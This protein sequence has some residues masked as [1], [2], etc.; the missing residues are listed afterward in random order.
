MPRRVC[1]RVTIPVIL[2]ERSQVIGADIR[3]TQDVPASQHLALGE[4]VARTL[5][6]SSG[7]LLA[8]HGAVACGRTV[9][10][11]VFAAQ[12]GERIA[13]MYL[14]ARAAATP[15]PFPQAFADSERER[16]LYRYGSAAD[17]AIAEGA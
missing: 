16:W 8:N 10:K 14:L 9:D 15:I 7:V 5:G 1:L 6:E 11:A 17:H 2:E 3:C 4:E 13:Q 12:V